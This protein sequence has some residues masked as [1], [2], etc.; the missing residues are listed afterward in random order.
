M[1][2]NEID[3]VET[4]PSDFRESRDTIIK[5]GTFG[6]PDPLA[7]REHFIPRGKARRLAVDDHLQFARITHRIVAHRTARHCVANFG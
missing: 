1:D 2:R 4:E 6:G 3:D 7:A 5:R